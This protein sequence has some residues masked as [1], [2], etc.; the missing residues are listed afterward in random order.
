MNSS[1]NVLLFYLEGKMKPNHR[2]WRW[3]RDQETSLS[4]VAGTFQ[5]LLTTWI[6]SAGLFSLNTH[7]SSYCVEWAFRNGRFCTKKWHGQVTTGTEQSTTNSLKS[8]RSYH[9]ALWA[10]DAGCWWGSQC[11]K[12]LQSR[13]EPVSEQDTHYRLSLIGKRGSFNVNDTWV[14]VTAS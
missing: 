5:F 11:E 14:L 10:A 6:T 2:L 12:D 7:V 3:T 13:L 8:R 1:S 9:S 4:T